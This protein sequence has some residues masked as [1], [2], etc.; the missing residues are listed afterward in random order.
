[1]G[2]PF[3][4]ACARTPWR[5]D[6]SDLRMKA[7]GECK[8]DGEVAQGVCVCVCVYRLCLHGREAERL[9]DGSPFH[10]VS[11]VCVVCVCSA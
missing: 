9:G 3:P 8:G 1:M 5:L 4:P 11:V 6:A 7:R 2:C 10:H